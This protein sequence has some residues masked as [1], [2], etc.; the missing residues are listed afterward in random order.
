NGAINITAGSTA[1]NYSSVLWTSGGT[2][3]FTNANSL[4]TATYNP[5]PA[6]ITAGSVILTLTAIG[7]TGCGNAVST[8]T[9]T[10]NAVPE[11]FMITPGNATLCLGDVQPLTASEQTASAGV[12]SGS[13]GNININIPDAGLFGTGNAISNSIFVSGIP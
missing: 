2:G 12:F 8:K 13:S 6:D 4:S 10:I 5:S 1:N 3:T 11:T 7:N 9:L